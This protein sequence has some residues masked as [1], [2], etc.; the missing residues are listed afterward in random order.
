MNACLD[1]GNCLTRETLQFFW[2]FFE[3]LCPLGTCNAT[4]FSRVGLADDGVIFG[5]LQHLFFVAATCVCF[6]GGDELGANPHTFC[7]KCKRGDKSASVKNSA[8]SNNGNFSFNRID[9][10]R[11]KCHG[12]NNASMSTCFCPLCNNKVASACN[13]GNGMAHFAAH[14]A[15]QDVV[16]M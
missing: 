6:V 14:G 7:T 10:L 9:Y 11:N 15:H 5:H 4:C 1:C 13:C 12:G 16:C 8:R 2:V 3:M